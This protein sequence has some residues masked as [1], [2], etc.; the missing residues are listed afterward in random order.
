MIF[1]IPLNTRGTECGPDR[2]V[3]LPSIISYMEHC[4]WLWMDEPKLGLVEAV[5]QGHG[6]YVVEQSIAMNRR[7]GMGQK[8]EVRCAMTHAG[9]SVAEGLQDV[10]REDGVQLAHCRIRGAFMG[11]T[12]R[13]A[14]LPVKTRESVFT[15]ELDGVRG[16]AEAGDE[17][18]L[19]EPP[20][21]LRPGSLDLELPTERPEDADRYRITVRASDIDIFNHVNAANYVRFVASALGRIGASKS[22]HRAHLKYS[23]Q[24][25]VGNVLDVLTW[26]LGGDVY[27]A[28][29]QRGDEVLFRA[30]VETEASSL[31]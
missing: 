14:R 22:I 13:L 8:C 19:F 1:S 28:D 24:A 11:P 21:P 2:W 12:G 16:T 6:F 17:S 25:V 27:A 31:S 3:T 20:Q 9:R 30:V 18:S 26:N 15:G 23:G 10:L 29:I 5:H 7:F 4:R